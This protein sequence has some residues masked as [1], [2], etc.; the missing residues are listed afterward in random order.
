MRDYYHGKGKNY[1]VQDLEIAKNNMIFLSGRAGKNED[2][3]NNCVNMR[4][5]EDLEAI[6][7]EDNAWLQ[8][9]ID[10]THAVSGR[11]YVYTKKFTDPKTCIVDGKYDT[12]E[13]FEIL[14]N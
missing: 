5:R 3:Q 9:Q 1:T 8:L 13:D 12:G 7:C 14:N 2:H 10:C 4:I 11:R 6:W